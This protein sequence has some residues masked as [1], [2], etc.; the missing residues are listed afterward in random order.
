[1]NVQLL[2]CSAED[3]LDDTA[4]SALLWKKN[5]TKQNNLHHIGNWSHLCAKKVTFAYRGRLPATDAQMR[6]DI[7]FHIRF[8]SVSFCSHPQIEKTI[9]RNNLHLYSFAWNVIVRFVSKKN[10]GSPQTLKFIFDCA[11]K[12]SISGLFNRLIT[13]RART[14]SAGI[15]FFSF[16]FQIQAK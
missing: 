15:F 16:S 6:I 12:L 10:A 2:S 11:L 5:K 9:H 13:A 1:M 4:R 7:F 8:C 14:F 3:Q